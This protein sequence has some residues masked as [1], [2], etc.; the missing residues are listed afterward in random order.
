MLSI[1]LSCNTTP[2][3]CTYTTDYINYYSVILHLILVISVIGLI[4]TYMTFYLFA[5][6][7]VLNTPYYRF[8]SIYSINS[9]FICLNDFVF[10]VFAFTSRTRMFFLEGFLYIENH[11]L[12]FLFSYITIPLWV[13]FYTTAGFLDIVIILNRVCFFSP[14]KQSIFKFKSILK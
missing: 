2:Y 9:F 13:I 7:Q 1:Y 4:N 3:V 10:I 6:V 14:K 11:N 12:M 5:S 8:L